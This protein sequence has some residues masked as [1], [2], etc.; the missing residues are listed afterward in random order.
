MLSRFSSV[1][2]LLLSKSETNGTSD[3]MSL[4][5]LFLFKSENNET[6]D[7]FFSKLESG[8]SLDFIS[9]LLL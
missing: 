3:L 6:S 7:D 1:G 4:E 2:E 5:E 9:V 8:D